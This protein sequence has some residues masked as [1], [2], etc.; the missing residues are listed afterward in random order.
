MKGA[1]PPPPDEELHEGRCCV[2]PVR[3]GGT[4]GKYHE[5]SKWV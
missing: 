2:C 5:S 1:L 4:E 3:L